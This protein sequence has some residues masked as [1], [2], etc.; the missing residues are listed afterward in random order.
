MGDSDWFDPRIDP[1]PQ[2]HRWPRAQWPPAPDAVL[3]GDAVELRP[4]HVDDTFDLFV[5]LD[6]NAVWMHLP[7]EQPYKVEAM[8]ELVE[9]AVATRF[10]W[11]VRSRVDGE[12]LG[13]TSF[14]DTSVHDARAEIGATQYGYRHWGGRTNPECKLL[15][16]THAFD[17]LAMG[18]VQLKTDVRN[19]RSQR[20]I[21]RLGATY[22]GTLGRYQRRAD[23]TVRD[24]VLFAVTAETWPQVREGL[25]A[26]LS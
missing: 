17:D 23:G 26:R 22:E 6:D 21:A 14:L 13:W 1:R 8:R 9:E 5:A 2:D 18:R 3:T 15:L 19:V 20:A 16:L 25:R 4:T 24:T 10:P 7:M 12:V 11:T